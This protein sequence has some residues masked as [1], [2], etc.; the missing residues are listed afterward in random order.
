MLK[1]VPSRFQLLPQGVQAKLTLAFVLMSCVPIAML[2]WIAAWYAFP[3]T[4]E[5]FPTLGRFIV[6][7]QVDPT[8]A[9]W[10]L[11]AVI[12]LTILV[13][14][15]G[16]VYLTMKIIE[17]VTRMSREAK[18]LAEDPTSE[19]ELGQ[20]EDELGDLANALNS[21][22]GRIREDMVELK[23]AETRTKQINLE[24]QKRMVILSSL[25][26]IGELIGSAKD[27]DT[28]LDLIVDRLGGVEDHAFS[29]LC[30]QPHDGLQVTPRRAYQLDVKRLTQSLAATSSVII[31]AE[32][33]P[34]DTDRPMWEALGR[35][36]MLMQPVIVRQRIMGL[37]AVGNHEPQYVFSPEMV[38]LVSVFAKQAA[39]ALENELLLRKNKALAVRDELTGL[40]NENFIRQRLDEEIKRAI[41]YQRPCAIAVFTIDG[42]TPYR[43]QRGAAEADRALKKVARVI[44]DTVT[45]IDRV[46]RL[47]SQEFVV[48]LPERSKRQAIEVAEEIRRRVEFAFASSVDPEERLT[49]SGSVAENPLDGVTAEDLLMKSQ[50]MVTDAAAH[51]HNAVLV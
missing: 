34:I 12:A 33:P 5:L 7:A 16:G 23:G 24:I 29:F 19:G 4:R 37:L 25:L 42:F 44:Q 36:N 2:L 22:T 51:S 30:L 48:V 50:S 8:A 18:R 39:I 28:V 20:Q 9:T 43:E 46:G 21:L 38:D 6:D 1:D 31:D 3:Y 17:P 32:H 26:Q 49:V 35:P 13:A 14:T 47:N 41:A 45:E 11:W 15:L 40:Y 27:L 10:W